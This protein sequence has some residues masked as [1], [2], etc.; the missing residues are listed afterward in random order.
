MPDR[1]PGVASRAV[2]RDVTTRTRY[3]RIR[4]RAVERA[5]EQH[6]D[7]FRHPPTAQR[8]REHQPRQPHRADRLGDNDAAVSTGGRAPLLDLVQLAQDGEDADRGVGEYPDVRNVSPARIVTPPRGSVTPEGCSALSSAG[9]RQTPHSSPT[10]RTTCDRTRMTS[11]TRPPV[12]PRASRVPTTVSGPF[13]A[14]R[15]RRERRGSG[16]HAEGRAGRR[17]APP[18]R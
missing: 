13:R 10:R 5:G 1:G 12:Q 7:V 2:N 18:R 4:R 3:A 6:P 15:E 11:L 9:T 16:W 14:A 17:R 8:P